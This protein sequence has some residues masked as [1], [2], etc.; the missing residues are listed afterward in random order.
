MAQHFKI[1]GNYVVE[2][3]L[4]PDNVSFNTEICRQEETAKHIFCKTLYFQ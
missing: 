1:K 4:K 3:R 2:R